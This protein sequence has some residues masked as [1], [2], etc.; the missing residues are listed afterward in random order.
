[1]G[2]MIIKSKIIENIE[3]SIPTSIKSKEFLTFGTTICSI[4]Q[5]T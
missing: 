3:G 4:K 1:M 5:V 2:L